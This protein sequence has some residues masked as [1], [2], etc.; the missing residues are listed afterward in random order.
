MAVTDRAP[1]HPKTRRDFE[2]ASSLVAG[3]AVS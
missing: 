1:G 2:T 3:H